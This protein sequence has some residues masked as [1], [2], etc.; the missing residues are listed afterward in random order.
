MIALSIDMY[1]KYY[2]QSAPQSEVNKMCTDECGCLAIPRRTREEVIAELIRF[3]V[4]EILRRIEK[5]DDQPPPSVGDIFLGSEC[6]QTYQAMLG[7]RSVEKLVEAL[8]GE[9]VAHSSLALLVPHGI[10]I[11]AGFDGDDP[12]RCIVFTDIDPAFFAG[13]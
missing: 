3:R 12:G 6:C 5:Q 9:R 10:S 4:Q 13:D 8:F 11:V 7:V 1:Y 2:Y